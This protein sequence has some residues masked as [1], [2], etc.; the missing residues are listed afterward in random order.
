MPNEQFIYLGDTARVPYGNKSPTAILH[1]SIENVSF[2]MDQKIKL[3]VV[4]CHT[5]CTYALPN[6]QKYFPIPIVGVIDPGFNTLVKATK[7]FQIALLG[8]AN[9]IKSGAYQRL[10][11]KYHPDV[12]IHTIACPLFVP[13]IEEGFSDHLMVDLAAYEYLHTLK[14]TTIDAA[15]LACTHY[16]LIYESIKKTLP[17]SIKLIDPAESCAECVLSVLK[18]NNLISNRTKAPKHKFFTTDSPEKF[19]RLAEKFL[20]FKPYHVELKPV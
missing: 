7:N 13:L 8:T 20:G 14:K 1:Y 6:L 4:A 15:L 16:P 9:T 17:P 2:L 5:V 10:L 18:R 11:L 19:Q 3:L 12:K